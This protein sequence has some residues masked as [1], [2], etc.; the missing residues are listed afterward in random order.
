MG[1]LF[2]DEANPAMFKF[3]V[4]EAHG[5]GVNFDESRALVE[6]EL[7][8]VYDEVLMMERPRNPMVTYELTKGEQYNFSDQ[9][10]VAMVGL[11]W[12]P[13]DSSRDI[14]VDGSVALFDGKGSVFQ[15]K[16]IIFFFFLN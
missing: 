12:D 6:Q 8:K 16:K 9:V 3:A 14:D 2:R 1:A 7:A 5:T 4:M 15:K 11:G 10:A 13:S